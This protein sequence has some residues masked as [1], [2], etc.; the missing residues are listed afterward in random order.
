MSLRKKNLMKKFKTLATTHVHVCFNAKL[1]DYCSTKCNHES[2]CFMH[3]CLCT[4]QQQKIH[5]CDDKSLTMPY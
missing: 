4:S 1:N 5:L 2:N 3:G